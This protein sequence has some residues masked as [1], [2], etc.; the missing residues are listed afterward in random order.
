MKRVAILPV[1][2]TLALAGCGS[3]ETKTVTETSKTSTAPSGL[4]ESDFDGY[5]AGALG[6][7]R[8]KNEGKKP[9]GTY[10]PATA[11]STFAQA[12]PD[13]KLSDGTTVRTQ[14]RETA[15]LLSDAGCEDDASIIRGGI[16]E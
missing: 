2:L 13:R 15:K 3:S 11:A 8:R 7:C 16:G 9:E 10:S 14:M 12:D 5:L 6:S 1:L 4:Q